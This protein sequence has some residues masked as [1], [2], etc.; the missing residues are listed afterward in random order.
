MLT[1]EKTKSKKMDYVVW[2]QDIVTVPSIDAE[3]FHI[4]N[5]GLFVALAGFDRYRTYS[6]CITYVSIVI[7]CILNLLLF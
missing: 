6:N 5:Q 7:V 1:V 4:P 2:Y 3:V